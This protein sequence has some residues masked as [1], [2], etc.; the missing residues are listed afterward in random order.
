[1]TRVTKEKDI[2]AYTSR[3]REFRWNKRYKVHSSLPHRRSWGSG[4]WMCTWTAISRKI[5]PVIQRYIPTSVQRSD[6]N[7]SKNW[8]MGVNV[9]QVLLP[10]Y[11][12]ASSRSHRWRRR[13]NLLGEEQNKWERWA[14]GKVAKTSW[15]GNKSDGDVELGWMRARYRCYLAK[16]F[17]FMAAAGLQRSFKPAE[18][19][20]GG[21]MGST[22]VSPWGP[23]DVSV[24]TGEDGRERHHRVLRSWHWKGW[25]PTVRRIDCDG[26]KNKKSSGYQHSKLVIA[27]KIILAKTSIDP[28]FAS[29]LV[30][31]DLE[32]MITDHGRISDGWLSNIDF[33][34]TLF[35]QENFTSTSFT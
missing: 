13:N 22:M 24:T 2:F 14:S 16:G 19:Y 9:A 18:V 4:R 33:S 12:R 1:M 23:G 17:P 26:E 29:L 27:T 35:A 7:T 30:S 25:G 8:V 34:R 31:E 10:A 6:S 15:R 28:G 21:N 11:F 20:G 32:G 3:Y 5:L